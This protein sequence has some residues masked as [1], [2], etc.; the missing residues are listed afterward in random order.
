MITTDLNHFIKKYSLFI[1]FIFIGS[2]YYAVGQEPDTLLIRLQNEIKLTQEDTTKVKALIALGDYQ[3]TRNFR[4]AEKYLFDALE[5][6]EKSTTLNNSK[7]RATVYEALG[8]VNKRKG[9]YP[10][11]VNFYL[12]AKTLYEKLNDSSNIADIYHNIAMVFRDQKEY[13]KAVTYFKKAIKI[14]EKLH[15]KQGVAIGYNMMGVAY[16]QSKKMDSAYKS[17]QKAKDIFVV[18]KDEENIY[19]VNSN[20]AAWYHT[21]KEYKKAIEMYAKNLEYDIKTNRK[22]SLQRI[23]YNLAGSHMQL[24]EYKIALGYAEKALKEAKIQEAKSRISKSYLRRSFLQKKMGNYK[25]AL[26][27]YRLYKKYSDSV[28]NVE[29]AKKIQA[30][31][32]SHKFNRER[33]TDSLHYAKEKSE[34]ELISNA[35]RSQKQLYLILL[36]ISVAGGITI[37]YLIRRIYKN[38]AKRITEELEKNKNEL[39]EFTKRL[40]D[41]SN[42]QEALIKELEDLKSEFGEK[43]SI[44]NIQELTS[45]RILTNQDWYVFREKFIMVYPNFYNNIKSKGFKL[46]KSEERLIAMEKLKLDTKQIANMLAI[47][48]DSVIMNRYRLRKKINA[49]KAAPILEYLEN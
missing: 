42:I 49:P 34:L 45:T 8:I 19:R 1:M 32:L 25:E 39:E 27:D 22:L 31:E 11:A 4:E 12:Q 40:I 20:L 6:I 37:V 41:K 43:Q 18:L 9:N 14:K 36:I 28:F 2:F 7:Q 17:Y 21:K 29:N 48:E 47:S 5:L 15:E 10:E 46:T 44:K 3:I 38:R 35:E 26:D 13:Q 24:K 23:Y 33:L 16:R 30:L